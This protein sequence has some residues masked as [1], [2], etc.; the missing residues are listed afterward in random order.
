[1][2]GTERRRQLIDVARTLF[3]ERGYEGTS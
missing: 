1:M 2:T 3:A